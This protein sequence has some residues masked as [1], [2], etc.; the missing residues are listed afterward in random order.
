MKRR[1][2]V[3][4]AA[5]GAAAMVW[6]ASPVA[7]AKE[8]SIKLEKMPKLQKVDGWASFKVEEHDQEILFI[9]VTEKRVVAL[10][11]ESGY[12]LVQ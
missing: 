8:V 7:F 12:E 10:L 1:T 9:R 5:V 2:F 3:L 6:L 4:L 11:T